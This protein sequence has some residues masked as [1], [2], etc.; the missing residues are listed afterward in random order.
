MAGGSR[1]AILAA[2][3]ANLGI[4]IAKFAGVAITR[5]SS[6]L[7]EGV[8]PVADTSNQALLLLGG[9][10]AA[11]PATPEHPFGYGRE[12]YFWAFVVAVVLFTLGSAFA[13]YEGIEKLRRDFAAF[14]L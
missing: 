10:R 2:F 11:R 4:A 6:M 14:G 7:A 8:H 5:S 1:R 9:R 3:F 13:L 12:R